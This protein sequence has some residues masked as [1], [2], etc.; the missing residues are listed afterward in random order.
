MALIELSAVELDQKIQS[1]LAKNPALEVKDPNA[2]LHPWYYTELEP[3]V[4]NLDDPGVT[5]YVRANLI[6]LS[7]FRMPLRLR[8][9][10]ILPAFL[11]DLVMTRIAAVSS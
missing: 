7:F 5:R 6:W 8:C 10:L 2:D 3:V 1:E 11:I 4:A 9:W